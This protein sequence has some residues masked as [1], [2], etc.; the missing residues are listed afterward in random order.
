MTPSLV[1]AGETERIRQALDGMADKDSDLGK[2]IQYNLGIVCEKRRDKEG[3]LQWYQKIMA[4][5]IGYRD[6]SSRVSQIMS[7]KW[8]DEAEVAQQA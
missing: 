5:D 2:D 1:S 7:G 4:V 8:P 6:V 3:S